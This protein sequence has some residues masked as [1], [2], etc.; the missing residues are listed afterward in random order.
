[1]STI[2]PRRSGRIRSTAYRQSAITPLRL[3]SAISSHSGSVIRSIGARF[4]MPWLI[5][6]ISGGPSCSAHCRTICSAADQWERF[7]SKATAL[8]PCR[9][10]ESTTSRAARSLL[11]NP[12]P[13]AA[14]ARASIKAVARPMHR[15]A[16]LTR[17][18]RFSKEIGNI[19]SRPLSHAGPVDGVEEELER[20]FRL[21]PVLNPEPEQD[22]LPLPVG[23]RDGRRAANQLLLSVDP[24]RKQHVLRIIR[25]PGEHGPPHL[26][27]RQHRLVGDWL[28]DKGGR[29][30]R[31]A[32]GD[33]VVAV[34]GNAKDRART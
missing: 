12:T 28:V 10:M 13:T 30:G 29:L 32:V 34:Q 21:R 33:R 16:P 1:M 25:V 6:R 4:Q 31:H 27:A 11:A 19:A 20:P 17:A 8:P 22:D 2:D 5:T 26:L 14:P 24:A 7:A 3:T 15:D 9:E 23:Q 18:V